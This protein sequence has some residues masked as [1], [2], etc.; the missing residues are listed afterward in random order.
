MTNK[1]RSGLEAE[2]EH[3]NEIVNKDEVLV[4]S[5]VH[6]RRR[7]IRALL[8]IEETEPEQD[9]SPGAGGKV[10]SITL[11]EPWTSEIATITDVVECFSLTN[12]FRIIHREDHSDSKVPR[13]SQVLQQAHQGSQGTIAWEDVPVIPI[14]EE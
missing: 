10:F 1:K 2:L 14:G 7:E 9:I 4:D 3:L 8:K 13:I 5:S 6:V 11:E 12:Q